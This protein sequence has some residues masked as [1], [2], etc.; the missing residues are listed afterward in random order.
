MTRDL[1]R[2]GAR[3]TSAISVLRVARTSTVDLIAAELRSAIFAG[4]LPVGAAIGEV[5]I[6]AQLGVSRSPLREAAQRLVQEGLLTSIPGRG[7]RVTEIPI[8]GLSDVYEARLAIE[9]QAVRILCRVPST[10]LLDTIDLAFA[11]LATASKGDDARQIG[12]ADLEFHQILVDSA[13]SARLSKFM[14]TLVVHTRI[15]SYSIPSG[16]TARRDISATYATLLT[17]LRAA[18]AGT[19][20]EAL[21][22][23]F[24]DAVAR[25]RGDDDSVDTV[26]AETAEEPLAFTPLEV[27]SALDH[28]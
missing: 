15:A 8:E 3:S 4:A 24:A 23:Q 22:Q 18:D 12:D 5:E 21:E 14:S 17:A 26:E 7:L 19:A 20:I 13:G 16:Y 28:R 2:L 10:S 11:E 6:A 25:L 27:G 9:S 1:P